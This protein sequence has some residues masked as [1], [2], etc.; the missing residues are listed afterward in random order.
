MKE[1]YEEFAT[2]TSAHGFQ[3]T[4]GGSK[5]KRAFGVVVIL[6][7]IAVASIFTFQAINDF[8][9]GPGFS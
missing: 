5:G 7:F 8:F 9:N 1:T 6:V 2:S 4:V 3:Y